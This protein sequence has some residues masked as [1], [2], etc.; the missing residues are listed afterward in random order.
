[1]LEKVRRWLGKGRTSKHVGCRAEEESPRKSIYVLLLMLV[2][3]CL[4]FLFLIFSWLLFSSLMILPS[5]GQLWSIAGLSSN[6]FFFLD[7]PVDHWC[8][9]LSTW[10]CW[11][12]CLLLTWCMFRDFFNNR[13]SYYIIAVAWKLWV[14][15]MTNIL[16]SYFNRIFKK[17]YIYHSFQKKLTFPLLIYCAAVLATFNHARYRYVALPLAVA[18]LYCTMPGVSWPFLK[19]QPFRALTWCMFG[20]RAIL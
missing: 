5:E 17:I 18:Y 16:S 12:L 3:V 13:P 4:C 15:T 2:C 19:A 8:A 6:F 10:I 14:M 1:M 11:V 20:V 7:Q 9:F